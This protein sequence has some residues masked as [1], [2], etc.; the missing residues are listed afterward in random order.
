M[1]VSKELL[2]LIAYSSVLVAESC[3]A[4]PIEWVRQIGTGGN[5][6]AFGIS[7]D[8]SGRVYAAGMTG[9]SL[10]GARTAGLDVFAAYYD[11]SG[12]VVWARQ[13][14]TTTGDSGAL[15]IAAD[16]AGNLFVAGST[17]GSLFGPN[18][19]PHW[20]TD[21][22]LAKLDSAGNLLWG[23]QFGTSRDDVCRGVSADGTGS[24]YV[25]G[26]SGEDV[27]VSKFDQTGNQ[28]W[29][30]Q[31]GTAGTDY[32]FGISA[33]RF[34]HV[35][36]TGV[37]YDVY[38]SPPNI[39]GDQDAVLLKYDSAGNLEWMRELGSHVTGQN[40][41]DAGLSVAADEFGNVYISGD[42]AQTL[43]GAS[44]GASDAFVAKYDSV[45][46]LLWIRQ[47]GAASNDDG[48]GVTTDAAGNVYVTGTQRGAH[49]DGDA[50]V[51]KF[52]PS[53]DMV[54]MQLLGSNKGDHAYGISAD[55]A[56]NVYLAG[57]TYGNIV[58]VNAGR[59]DTFLAKILGVPE[60]ATWTNG[61]VASFGLVLLRGGRWR[62]IGQN[63]HPFSASACSLG[64]R[65]IASKERTDLCAQLAALF[66][67]RRGALC[68]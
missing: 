18:Q 15:G 67:L 48:S 46:N 9:G 12:S 63:E 16:G 1:S 10:F 6:V 66:A 3:L 19:G 52:T 2:R 8:D 53:G 42:T 30:R 65:T 31:W 57:E 21:S 33:D 5:D 27:F 64:M 14:G 62:C 38:G 68:K 56:G 45:G 58:S 22:F 34:G 47:F 36:V 32:G 35:Y 17:N 59:A 20:S 49:D 25:T 39:S 23:R 54:W 50:Y 60:P 37:M 41:T 28:L 43:A 24:V 55:A 7:S 40:S 4:Q 11:A 13:F 26:D 51:R 61:L 44:A 29:S